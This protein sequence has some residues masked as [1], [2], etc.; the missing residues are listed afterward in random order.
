MFNYSQNLAKISYGSWPLWGV[1]T[2]QKPTKKQKTASQ[3]MKLHKMIILEMFFC[4][5]SL[6][7]VIIIIIISSS[8]HGCFNFIEGGC[9][10]PSFLPSFLE[11]F[12]NTIG[13]RSLNLVCCF[14]RKKKVWDVVVGCKIIISW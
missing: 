5:V 14:Q 4:W 6:F 7:I 11:A 12:P 1:P 3:L 9:M 2:S 8:S 10:Y 13:N